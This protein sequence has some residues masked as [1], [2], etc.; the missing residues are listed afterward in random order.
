MKKYFF[1]ALLVLLSTCK[2]EPVTP[3]TYYVPPLQIVLI[4]KPAREIKTGESA[5]FRWEVTTDH[6]IKEYYYFLNGQSTRI[7]SSSKTFT[8][9]EIGYYTFYVKAVTTQNEEAN[10]GTYQFQ[11]IED[12]P[13]LP[14]GIVLQENAIKVSQSD[15]NT[16]SEITETSISFSDPSG[17]INALQVGD[18]IQLGISSKTPG[19]SLRMITGIP[20]LSKTTS[21]K[22][23]FTK[24]ASLVELIKQGEVEI[25][26]QLFNYSKNNMNTVCYDQDGNY[27]T[28]SDQISTQTDLSL[29]STLQGSIDFST[30]LKLIL[31]FIIQGEIDLDLNVGLN[32]NIN[33]EIPLFENRFN[34]IIIW[35]DPPIIITPVLEV[36]LKV[37]GELE[38]ALTTGF[39]GSTYFQNTLSYNSG[40]SLNKNVLTN[41]S[42]KETEIELE[43]DI[44]VTL[45]TKLGF[46]VYEILGPTVGAEPYLE[47]DAIQNRTPFWELYAGVNGTLGIKMGFLTS[48]IPDPN[49]WTITGPRE[50]IGS[51]GGQNNPPH[52]PSIPYPEDGSSGWGPNGTLSWGGGD[53]DYD[54]VTNELYFGISQNPPLLATIAEN[55]Y[56]VSNLQNNTDY[57]WYVRATDEHGLTVTGPLWRFTSQ[58]GLG[59]DPQFGTFTDTRDGRVY[60]T[61]KIGE[62]WW[63][64][65]NLDYDSP[66]SVYYNNDE[67]TYKDYGHLYNWEEAKEACP[68]GWHLPSEEEFKTL[69]ELATNK[70]SKILSIRQNS[71]STNETGF[72]ALLAGYWSSYSESFRL[73][74]RY[75]GFLSS[76]ENNSTTVI[77]MSISDEEE[78][79]R[80]TFHGVDKNDR[81]SVRCIKD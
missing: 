70:A 39:K 22:K 57:Y 30:N 53:P 44:K 13:P 52:V 4:Q 9:L 11:V 34:P 80:I 35:P 37:N 3:E 78:N 18:V 6:Q 56:P 19:G 23:F 28:I 46:I 38:G 20:G 43:G 16:I 14:G 45:V 66:N 75:A 72:S 50:L 69:Q 12:S 25:N 74:G 51:G 79:D 76:T 63:F 62:Q 29:S 10:T 15:L 32:Q 49:P 33:K 61:V 2:E 64:A 36:S 1:V 17:E 26:A 7:T 60:K 54:H 40:W 31:S 47:F 24:M 41:F 77:D 81:E 71:I 21:I 65:E 58:D 42:S 67:T 27:S 73:F 59:G 68:L 55:Y 48:F 5:T 8:N